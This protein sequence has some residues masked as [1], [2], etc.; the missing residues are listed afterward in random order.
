[1]VAITPGIQPRSYDA[2]T[3]VDIDFHPARIDG[4]HFPQSV[5]KKLFSAVWNGVDDAWFHYGDP[6]GEWG[7]REQI[8]RYLYHARGVNS[9]P[10]RIIIGSGMPYAIDLL[11]HLLDTDPL[12]VGMED[13][14][15]D[16]AKR[17]FDHHGI[18]ILPISLEA[19]GL[20]VERLWHSKANLVYATP[21]HQFPRGMVMSYTKR[22]QFLQ[23]A[24]ERHAY[25][26]EDDYDGEF[27]YTE[28]PIPSLQ[29]LDVGD[30]VIY[31]G[32]FSKSLASALRLNYL[33]LPHALIPRLVLFLQAHDSPV[34]RIAA[35]A[36]AAETLDD[37]TTAEDNFTNILEDSAS[38]MQV[39]PPN[40]ALEDTDASYDWATDSVTAESGQLD[41]ATSTDKD[42]AMQDQHELK[43]LRRYIQC[44][45]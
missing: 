31:I 14:G 26:I 8:S 35:L 36:D 34:P 5:W 37:G 23:W 18:P 42:H 20:S 33:V 41:N 43:R 22:K 27:R 25:I 32:T 44:C 30:S 4:T 40:Q 1:M 29:G 3:P 6:Q 24:H 2:P 21:F 16:K 39:S 15:Y 28:R 7:L 11:C 9:T 19:D 17:L 38:D 45:D 10:D 13:P 12:V